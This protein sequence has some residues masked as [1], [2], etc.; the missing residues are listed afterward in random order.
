MNRIKVECEQTKYAYIAGFFDGE[1]SAMILTIK[2][3]R[4]GIFRFR[5][6]IKIAQKSVELLEILKEMLGFGTVVKHYGCPCLQINGSEKTKQFIK[7]IG[8]YCIL[9]QKQL[10]LLVELLKI[11]YHNNTGYSK[12]EMT[13]MI[14]LRNEV[15]RLNAQNRDNIKLKYPMEVCP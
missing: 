6:V 2:R 12:G 3:K 1:G 14:K 11:Q 10:L 7:L 8:P 5:A 4:I 13:E 9:K 15:H